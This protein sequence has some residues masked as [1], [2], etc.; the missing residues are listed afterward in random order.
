[1]LWVDGFHHPEA[2]L[3]AAV[4]EDAVDVIQEHGREFL[5]GYQP[6]PSQLIDSTLQIAQHGS[7]IA[8]GPQPLQAFLWKVG[9][10]HPPIE[11][12]QIV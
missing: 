3:C 10:H 9:F 12:E 7:S 1:M 2:Y 5:K 8:V 6:L 11:G 4:V